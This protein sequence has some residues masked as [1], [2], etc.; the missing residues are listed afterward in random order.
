MHAKALGPGVV[1]CAV[2]LQY[3]GLPVWPANP[4]GSEPS[5][6]PWHCSYHDVCLILLD[7]ALCVRN[8]VL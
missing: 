3:Q 1:T 6:I 5:T 7:Q 2:S 8:E 4:H